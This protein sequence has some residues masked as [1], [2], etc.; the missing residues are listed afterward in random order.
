MDPLSVKFPTG[1][2]AL[3]AALRREGVR[4]EAID[5]RLLYTGVSWTLHI[6]CRGLEHRWVKQLPPEDLRADTAWDELCELIAQDVAR[7]LDTPTAPR[8]RGRSFDPSGD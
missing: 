7:R 3:R 4:P 8:E 1:D 5:A 2:A 6:T